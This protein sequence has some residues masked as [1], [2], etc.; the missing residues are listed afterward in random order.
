MA[1]TERRLDSGEHSPRPE[2][3]VGQ[4]AERHHLLPALT[5]M[6]YRIGDPIDQ[7]QTVREGIDSLPRT[8]A[9]FPTSEFVDG[10][11]AHSYATS[12]HLPTLFWLCGAFRCDKTS[13]GYRWSNPEYLHGSVHRESWGTR[14]Q[15]VAFARQVAPLGTV[16]VADIAR[17]FGTTADTLRGQF[18]TADFDWARRRRAG[19]R[20]LARTV[21]LI[22][23]WTEYTYQAVCDALGMSPAAH[24]HQRH[25]QIPDSWEPPADPTS[26]GPQEARAD[27]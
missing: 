19:R 5:P 27:D 1:T 4:W 18:Q 21:E 12:G 25:T 6:D 24:R 20:R 10:E 13:T 15:R 14:A 16:G 9:T 8:A 7:L 26:C 23:D 22:V 2:R 11:T 3:M 17:H